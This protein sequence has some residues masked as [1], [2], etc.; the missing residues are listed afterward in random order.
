[1]NNNS[2]I[3]VWQRNGELWPMSVPTSM[4]WNDIGAVLMVIQ[5]YCITTVIEIGV[6]QGGLT[7]VFAARMNYDPSFKYFG[8]EWHR[9]KISEKIMSMD[10]PIRIDDAF[11]DDSI[12]LV[13]EAIQADRNRVLILCDGGDK[14]REMKT[15]APLLREGDII[16]A[17]D[18]GREITWRDIPSD[19]IVLNKEWMQDTNLVL[20]RKK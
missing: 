7:A 12:R 18:Y 8:I 15:Y 16:M 2:S 3:P 11:S 10:I 13:Q 9:S 6:D 5:E 1:M 17:H 14:P 19:V 4:T 20:A